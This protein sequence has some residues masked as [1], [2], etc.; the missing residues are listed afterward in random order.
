MTED[1]DAEVCVICGEDL[2][3]VHQATCQFCG[4]KFHHPW[5]QDAQVPKCGLIGSHEEALAIVFLCNDCYYG[6][7]P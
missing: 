1:L 2:D 6:R 7:R 4:G 5:S 3:E